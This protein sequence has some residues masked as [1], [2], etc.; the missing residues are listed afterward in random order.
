MRLFKARFLSVALPPG[1]SSRQEF[2]TS[3][4]EKPPRNLDIRSMHELSLTVMMFLG[5]SDL[6]GAQS[7]K[8]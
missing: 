3:S 1:L 4:R 2:L 7:T 6:N 8:Y 5:Y